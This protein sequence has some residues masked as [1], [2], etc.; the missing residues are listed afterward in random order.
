MRSSIFEKFMSEWNDD[1]ILRLW[2]SLELAVAQKKLSDVAFY[3][4]RLVDKCCVQPEL[5]V[6]QLEKVGPTDSLG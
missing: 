5:P 2:G 4:G 3:L 6:I 1:Q